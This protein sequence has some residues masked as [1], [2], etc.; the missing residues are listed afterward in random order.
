[1]QHNNVLDA[2]TTGRWGLQSWQSYHV[3]AGHPG[4]Q[5]RGVPLPDQ[6]SASLE[7]WG[8]EPFLWVPSVFPP[9][10]ETS[11]CLQETMLP[12]DPRS[13]EPGSP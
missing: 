7:A 13:L 8:R 6:T 9:K 2:M 11:L 5:G 10:Q 1:M 4:G 3:R 12:F